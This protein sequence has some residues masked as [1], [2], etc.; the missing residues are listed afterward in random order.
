ME[1]Q[2]RLWKKR[3]RESENEIEWKHITESKI[4]RETGRHTL[5]HK[6]DDEKN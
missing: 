1:R 6:S 4:N 3:E 5:T 2:A